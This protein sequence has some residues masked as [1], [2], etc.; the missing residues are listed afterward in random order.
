MSFITDKIFFRTVQDLTAAGR[1]SVFSLLLSF[2]YKESLFF[3]TMPMMSS[4]TRRT[5]L[6]HSR[7]VSGTRNSTVKLSFFFS[8]PANHAVRVPTLPVS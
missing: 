8:M 2:E 3:T 4:R 1:T 6:Q 5:Q 7:M